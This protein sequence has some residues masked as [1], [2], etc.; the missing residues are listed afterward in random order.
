METTRL[1][2]IQLPGNAGTLL[3][4]FRRYDEFCAKEESRTPVRAN[5][6]EWQRCDP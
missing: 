6:D 2:A 5:R 4:S 3:D 1:R